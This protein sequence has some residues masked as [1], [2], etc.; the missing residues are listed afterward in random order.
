MSKQIATDS[1]VSRALAQKL[2]IRLGKSFPQGKLVEINANSLGSKYFS[3]SGKLVSKVFESVETLSDEEP[4]TLLCLF[5]DEIETLA[6]KREQ[7]LNGND[8]FDAMR[9]TNALLTAFDRLKNHPN[10]I[11]LCTSN[12]ITALVR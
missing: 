5:I 12:L 11:I 7:T 8:P 2:S 1:H 4:D 3:E 10:V 6:V 9:A